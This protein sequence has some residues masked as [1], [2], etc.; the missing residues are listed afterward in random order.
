[1]KLV[2]SFFLIIFLTITQSQ[3]GVREDFKYFLD[4][5]TSKKC[6]KLMKSYSKMATR[7][8]DLFIK[9]FGASLTPD[10]LNP[11]NSKQRKFQE[12][13]KKG[14]SIIKPEHRDAILPVINQLGCRVELSKIT[15]FILQ[16]MMAREYSARDKLVREIKNGTA[17]YSDVSNVITSS[18]GIIEEFFTYIVQKDPEVVNFFMNELQKY[19]EVLQISLMPIMKIVEKYDLP[20]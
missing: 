10:G 5:T 17:K 4:Q 13:V 12:I 1:M 16:D 7:D 20:T 9:A 19:M 8:E 2:L 11:K 6:L 15:D 18:N 14:N 3:A